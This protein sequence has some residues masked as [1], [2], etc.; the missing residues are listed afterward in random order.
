MFVIAI[1]FYYCFVKKAEKLAPDY[2]KNGLASLEAGKSLSVFVIIKRDINIIA[3]HNINKWPP[4]SPGQL[5]QLPL[6]GQL[7]YVIFN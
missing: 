6:L 7:I 1:D 3:C 4:P 2:F 5:L